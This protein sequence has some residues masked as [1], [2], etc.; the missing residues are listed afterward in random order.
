MLELMREN[1]SAVATHHPNT[2]DDRIHVT[3]TGIPAIKFGGIL[4]TFKEYEWEPSDATASVSNNIVTVNVYGQYLSAQMNEYLTQETETEEQNSLESQFLEYDP[5]SPENNKIVLSNSSDSTVITADESTEDGSGKNLV[6]VIQDQDNSPLIAANY[7]DALD[8]GSD[9]GITYVDQ[10]GI[11]IIPGTLVTTRSPG[12]SVTEVTT[13]PGD[14]SKYTENDHLMLKYIE[15]KISRILGTKEINIYADNTF[16]E[17][18]NVVEVKWEG[19]VELA[20][21]LGYT[22]RPSRKAAAMRSGGDTVDADNYFNVASSKVARC[23]FD[24]V[25]FDA[26][27]LEGYIEIHIPYKKLNELR[28]ALI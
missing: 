1:K 25:D 20:K 15:E 26:N 8:G 10:K 3:I 16:V 18:S 2:E 27:P 17:F 4:T 5:S 22:W 14:K 7:Q 13:Q 6:D 9:M 12:K 24:I 19:V 11:K 21:L 28:D 23:T